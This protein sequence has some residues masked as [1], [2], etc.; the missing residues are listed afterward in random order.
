MMGAALVKYIL[1]RTALHNL[2]PVHDGY[3]V[4]EV[5]HDP[6]VMC[7]QDDGGPQL[8]LKIA[9]HPDYLG[10]DGHIQRR[11]GLV[12]NNQLGVAG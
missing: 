2:A 12:C 8:L 11:G 3:L 5:G 1:Q 4:A 9:H 7:D 10:L 6:Q